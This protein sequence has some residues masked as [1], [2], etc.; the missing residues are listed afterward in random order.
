MTT[1]RGAGSGGW[2][3]FQAAHGDDGAASTATADLIHILDAIELPT[4]ALRRDLTIG[5]FNKAAGVVLGL[6]P[7]DVGRASCDVS[8]I[9]GLPRLE[10]HCTQVCADGIES[11]IDFRDGD[12][13]FVVRI[14]PYP[15]DDGHVTGTLL[16][17]TNVTAFRASVDQAIYEREF[18]K[19]ILNTVAE[20]LVV[21]S[22]DQR[23]QSGNRAFYEMFATSRDQT[24]GV[25]LKE[26]ATWVLDLGPLHEQL[27]QIAR[28]HAFHPVEVEANSPAMG[29]RT[30]VLDARPLSLPG[31]PE[32]RV[33]LTL[34][35]ITERKAAEAAKDQRSEAQL[36]RSE[37]FLAEG[38]RLSLSGS[39]SWKPATD[40]VTWSEQLYRIY[41]FEVGVPVTLDLIRTRV[42]PEDVSLL[43][44][45]KTIDRE[46][47]GGHDFEWQY[48]LLMPDHSL[49]YMHAVAHATRDR[50]GQ[51]EYIAVVQDVTA[52]RM[53]ERQFRGLLE[54][55]PDAMVVMNRKGKIELVNAQLEKVFGYRRE[56]LLGRGIDILVPERFRGRHPSH[57]A[58]F[59]EQPRLRPM[60]EGL[61]L[62]GRRKDGTEFPVE[63]SLSPLET[64]QGTLVSAA[65]RDVTERKR[66]EM[67]LLALRD[68]LT[69][70][71]TAMGRLHELSTRL[72]AITDFQPLLGEILDSTIALQKADFGNI[73]IYDPEKQQ[74]EI[75]AQRGFRR[76]FLEYFKS[77]SDSSAACGRAMER[78]ERVIIE[79]VQVDAAF[80]PHRRLSAAAGYRAVQ[81]TPLFSRGGDFLGVL[82]THFRQPHRPSPHDL[83]LTD[84]Y[85]RHAAEII[86]RKRVDEARRLAEDALHSTRAELARVSR[87][88]TMGALAAAIAHEVNQPLAGIVTNASTCLRMLASDPPDLAGAGVTAHRTIRDANRASEVI[89]R[90]RAMFARRTPASESVD[91]NDAAREVLALLTSELRDARV[92][93]RTTFAEGLPAVCGDRVQLQQVILNLVRNAADA[94]RGVEGRPRE[95]EV[96]TVRDEAGELTLTVRDQG[97][98][99]D[100]ANLP[101]LFDAFFSTK[102]EGMGIGLS[103]SRSIIEAHRGRLWAIP[104]QGGPG[105]T[106]SFSLRSS[107]P[108]GDTTRS[109]P[110]AEPAS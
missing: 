101:R 69:T 60:G 98:G 88:T 70:E 86:D 51:L 93:L 28:G 76:E 61:N 16:T 10:Q 43:E 17:F 92:A 96:R 24:Q 42:H 11:R 35:D 104:N 90:L 31:Y 34:Q 91:L 87:L 13:W 22:A 29:R 82:S 65:V 32:R 85:A 41:E 2:T 21:L 50:D 108:E 23:I 100:P 72:L 95:L 84:L 89:Q 74:L 67:E 79:D 49:K 27:E 52:R 97:I 7:S 63:I 20:P 38:Q 80:A 81:S 40:E 33:L 26:F 3:C 68:E 54:S 57:R 19:T 1:R 110:A 103:I 8:V 25:A 66:A 71:L 107:A 94:L 56:D 18:T 45:M 55:A 15:R 30:L 53:A 77:V 102:S 105:M 59:L 58:G 75:F 37:A 14:S 44:K 47:D 12:T 9:A 39:F 99:I 62:Y 4:V 106:F 78:R 64:E 36:R 73:Q 83:R 5:C 109:A 46:Q 6:L 48:R